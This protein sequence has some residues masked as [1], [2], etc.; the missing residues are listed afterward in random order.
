MTLSENCEG[1]HIC[2]N[3]ADNE[4]TITNC[5]TKSPP[6]H[7]VISE[8]NVLEDITETVDS[9]DSGN[10]FFDLCDLDDS[11]MGV[12]QSI[13]SYLVEEIG[14]DKFR[15]KEDICVLLQIGYTVYPDS[16]KITIVTD[17]CLTLHMMRISNSLL[18]VSF[19]IQVGGVATFLV[20]TLTSTK[21]YNTAMAILV[22]LAV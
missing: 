17:K 21:T 6:K 1:I 9:G 16:V 14:L 2:Y 11:L 4:F 3:I 12:E 18:S 8:V 13:T 22:Q 19:K 20:Q 15:Y 7:Y 5:L 10:G